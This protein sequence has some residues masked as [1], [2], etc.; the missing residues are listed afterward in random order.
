M[1]ST[2]HPVCPAI[3]LL[4][5]LTLAACGNSSRRLDPDP[6]E[7]TVHSENPARLT[8]PCLHQG[9]GSEYVVGE[10]QRYSDLSRIPWSELGPGDTVRIHWR[11]TP[12]RHKLLLSSSGSVKQPIRICGVAGNGGERP[13]LSGEDAE[14]P[15]R[16]GYEENYFNRNHEGGFQGLGLIIISGDYG[17]KPANIIIEGL[18]LRDARSEYRYTDSSGKRSSYDRGAACIRIQAADNIVIRNNVLENCGNGIFTMSQGYNEASLTRNLL[19]E[20]NYLI[21]NGVPKSYYEHGMYIQAIGVTYQYNH[22]G[23]NKAGSLGATLKERVAGSVIRY[24]WFDSGGTRVM[25][26]VEVEDAKGWYLEQAYLQE[27][28]GS[29]PDPERLKKVR[30]AEIRYRSTHVYGNLIRHVGSKARATNLIHYGWDNDPV[31]ARAGTLYFF[32]NTISILDDRDRNWRIVLFDMDPYDR[33]GRIH[34]RE[35]VQAFNNIIYLSS[36]TSGAEPSYL[37]LGQESGTIEL[38]VNWISSGWQ[39][40]VALAECYPDQELMP[41]IR[42][43]ERLIPTVNAPAPVDPASLRT[44]PTP[45]IRGRAQPLPGELRNQYLPRYQYQRHQAGAPR[46]AVTTLGAMEISR[47]VQ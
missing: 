7:G 15:P 42:G 6:L 34:A 17:A 30:E 1:F 45:E 27:L 2:P 13:T 32:N 16:M 3:V 14:T 37:C 39:D 43:A 38:G 8:R 23:P 11:E 31:L 41:D 46:P 40:A 4:L 18:H 20:G 24:N 9:E 5:S 19:I 33:E 44:I 26:L 28:G 25:D 10:G 12:Y 22:F 29:A 35:T 47:Q 36:E 21:D